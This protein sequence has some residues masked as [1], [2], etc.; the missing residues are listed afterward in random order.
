[1]NVTGRSLSYTDEQFGTHVAH[2]D[3]KSSK[4][5]SA[6]H[7]ASIAQFARGYQKS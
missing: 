6:A 3:R 4:T 7:H 5:K 1:M 2:V